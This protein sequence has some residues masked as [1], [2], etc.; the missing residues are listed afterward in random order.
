MNRQDLNHLTNLVVG[1]AKRKGIL[2]H[3]SPEIQIKKLREET[4]ELEEALEGNPKDA[5]NAER[6]RDEIGDGFVVL[7]IL[8]MQVGLDPADCLST[9]EQKIR[10]RDVSL[11]KGDLIKA[12][13]SEGTR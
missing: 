1:W 12:G 4:D 13:D 6:I 7:I 3:G 9:A 10:N 2:D 11:V 5:Y 8:A